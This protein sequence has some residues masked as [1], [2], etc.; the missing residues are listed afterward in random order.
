MDGINT[1]FRE[2]CR[3]CGYIKKLENFHIKKKKF[4]N[5]NI[6]ISNT[7][8]VRILAVYHLRMKHY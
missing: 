1:P 3:T 6:I 4:R 2:I 8:G 5:G 7:D